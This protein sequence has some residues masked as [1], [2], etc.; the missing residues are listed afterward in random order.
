MNDG[1]Y[2]SL[3]VVYTKPAPDGTVS[4]LDGQALT[5][6]VMKVVADEYAK[7][8]E[9]DNERLILFGSGVFTAMLKAE[10]KELP[11]AEEVKA[12][13]EYRNKHGK[14]PYK[15]LPGEELC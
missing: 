9:Q 11:T 5:D 8:V 1:D 10:G 3:K 14:G 13:H 6:A 4:I 7:Q 15:L 12:A 2:F